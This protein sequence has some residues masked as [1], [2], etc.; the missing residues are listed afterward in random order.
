MKKHITIFFLGLFALNGLAQ[1]DPEV[2]TLAQ[3]IEQ[4]LE[5]NLDVQQGYLNMENGDIDVKDAKYSMY[6]DLNGNTS[7]RSSWGRSIDPTTNDFINTQS[8]F[9]SVGASTSLLL[10]DGFRIRNTIKQNQ[11]SFEAS[12]MDLEQT[13]DNITLNV[14]GSYMNV[15][16]NQELYENAQTQLNTTRRQLARTEK[17]VAA[18]ALPRSDL[19]ELQA[20]EATNELNLINQENAVNFSML[21]LKQFMQLPASKEIRVQV[22][23]INVEQVMISSLSLEDVYNE[24]LNQLPMIKGAELRVTSSQYTIQAAKG[25][26]YPRL[27]MMAGLNSNYSSWA[28]RDRFISDGGDP[29]IVPRQ[30]GYVDGTL[31]PVFTDFEMPS[32]TWA[33]GYNL[34][35]QIGD[36]LSKYM[37]VSLNIPIFNR[38]STRLNIQ[39]AEVNRRSQ[40]IRLEQ[41]KNTVRQN[42]ETAYYDFEAAVK[43]YNASLKQVSSRE[44][45]FRM[46]SQRYEVGAVD[47]TQ[48]QIS[49]NDLFRAK[50]DLLRAKFDLI[51]KTKI[52]DYYQGKPLEF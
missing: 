12:Q 35:N 6:P 42:I 5:H 19:L 28:N 18:G 34:P 24:A 49:E 20:Q 10:F 22:P 21:Q 15:I 36:N 25:G 37:G 44:E 48:Y 31:T 27:S 33:A 13:K 41:S 50:S 51:Y 39:R 7:Y 40:E 9:V 3:C 32:G 38:N 11:S 46:M 1:N 43:S 29:V 8:D 4:A 16:F 47:F 2:W 45:A 14:V 26:L 23:D 17:Q 30:I 52:L